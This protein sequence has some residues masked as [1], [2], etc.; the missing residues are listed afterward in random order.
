MIISQVSFFV[1]KRIRLKSSCTLVKVA[2]KFQKTNMSTCAI[3]I[4]IQPRPNTV[5]LV[6]SVTL[7]STTEKAST[8]TW[9]SMKKMTLTQKKW[10][11][12]ANTVNSCFHQLQNLK[13]TLNHFNQISRFHA[14]GAKNPHFGH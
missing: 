14:P 9:R 13:H 3:V 12:C 11:Y 4:V 8:V 1:S 2:R 5:I 10:K 7:F 6:V